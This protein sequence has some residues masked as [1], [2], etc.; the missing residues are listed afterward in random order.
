MQRAERGKG[1][2]KGQAGAEREAKSMWTVSLRT[3][4]LLRAGNLLQFENFGSVYLFEKGFGHTQL[5]L[6]LSPAS[7][8]KR[9][10]LAVLSG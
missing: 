7:V 4:L 9:S 10:L 1:Q 5:N 6:G 2:G 3:W 8:V